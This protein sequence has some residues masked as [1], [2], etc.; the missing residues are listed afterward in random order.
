MTTFTIA[1]IYG[2][3]ENA[4]AYRILVDRLWPRGITQTDAALDEWCKDLAPTSELRKWWNHDPESLN[5]FAD[6]YRAELD[7]NVLLPDIL[8]R[9]TTH[10]HV[11]LL[12]GAKDPHVN[13]AVILRDYLAEHS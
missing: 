8:S 6:R 9:L 12:Y 5:E 2:V 3:Q 11:T 7:D 10:A 13:H 4:D 1:R